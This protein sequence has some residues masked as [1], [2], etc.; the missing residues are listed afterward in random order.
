MKFWTAEELRSFLAGIEGHPFHLAYYVAAMTGARRGEVL[1]LKMS[2][3]DFT[4]KRMAIRRTLSCVG[5]KL[6]V[7]KPKTKKS[8]RSMDLD[9]KTIA[10]LQEHHRQQAEEWLANGRS[11][12]RPSLLFA[13]NGSFIHPDRFSKVFRNLVARSGLPVLRLHDLRHT[14]ASLLLLAGQHPKVVQERLG[15]SS[16]TVTMDL[17]SH[18]M[19]GLQQTAAAELSA[20][21][22][23][24]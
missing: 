9:E 23:G 18:L 13:R 17:Y 19:P 21:V 7:T 6:E 8:T 16:I 5:Y 12:A 15:H 20:M 3:I 14:H 11:G 4:N 24:R 2:D 22:F 1:A 10:M